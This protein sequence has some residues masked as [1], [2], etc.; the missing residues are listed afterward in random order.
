[1][2]IAIFTDTYYP[3]VNGVARTLKRYTD[4]LREHNYSVKVFAPM[5]E[6]GEY[7]SMNI[8]RFKSLSFFLYPECRIAF[9]NMLHIRAELE[10]FAPDIIHVATPFNIGLCGNYYAKKLN[11]PLV[12]SYHTD[13]DYYLQFYDLQFLSTILWSYMKWFHKPFQKLFVPSL[14][15]KMQV[16]EKG[17]A[18]VEIWPRGVDCELFHPYYRKNDVWEKYQI[19]KKYLLTYVGRLAPEKNV[20][21]LIEMAHSLPSVWKEKIQWLIVGDGP[22][23]G[24]MEEEAPTNM[25]FT[26]FL[27]GNELAE[28]YAASDVFVFPSPSE[29]F[30]NVMLEAMASGT[31][32][33]GANAGG[34]RNVVQEGV[35]GILCE[36]GNGM[37][38]NKAILRLLENEGIRNRMGMEGRRYALTQKWDVIFEKLL[39]SY[40]T[41]LKEQQK[42]KYA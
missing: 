33:I 26:G 1:M 35:T 23:R 8:H 37:E 15:T 34:V 38:M 10:R 19:S 20:D 42:Q 9:P 11:I 21:L 31:P 25:K 14:Q 16:E 40:S 13:F 12:G 28:L 36:P 39:Q 3:E 32:V 18:N 22:L 4:Y 41:V 29:T 6:S 7:V 17:F 5:P 2:K 30:G 27:K 24:K